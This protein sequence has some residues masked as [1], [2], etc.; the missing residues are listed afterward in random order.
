MRNSSV[1]VLCVL[2]CLALSASAFGQA[3]TTD[4]VGRLTDPDTGLPAAG[5][6][7]S[8]V[9]PGEYFTTTRIDGRFR[10]TNIPAGRYRFAFAYIPG[11]KDPEATLLLAKN[12]AVGAGPALPVEWQQKLLAE[13]DEDEEKGP[14]VR[15]LN[16]RDGRPRSHAQPIIMAE[17]LGV[18]WP[19]SYF[20]VQMSF[21]RGRCRRA[22]LRVIDGSTGDEVPF[23]LSNVKAGARNSVSSCTVTFPASLDPFQKKVYA[24]C[25]GPEG[26]FNEPVYPSSLKVETRE[27]TGEQILSNALVALMLPPAR[28]DKPLP[29]S[30]CPAPI[31]R[32]RGPDGVWFGDGR[33]VS[34]RTVK[35]FKCEEVEKGPLFKEFKITYEFAAKNDAADEK[36]ETADEKTGPADEKKAEP[37]AKYVVTLRLYADRDYVLIREEMSGK[38]DLVFRLSVQANLKPDTALFVKD[39]AAAIEKIRLPAKGD[40]TTLAVFRAWNP[41]GVRNSHNWY[42]L[43]SSG[44]RKDAVGLVQVNGS[45][46]YFEGRDGWGD[47]SWLMKS[48]DDD[49]VRLTATGE[50]GLYL[51]F[52]HR[53]GTREFALAVFDKT[54]NWDAAS[55]AAKRPP[56][57]KT[58]YL[59]RLHVHLSQL[60]IY[61]LLAIRADRAGITPRPRLLFNRKMYAS[62]KESFDENPDKFPTVLHDVFSNS[63]IH[64]SIIRTD[65]LSG[66]LALRH[67]F[68]GQP[69][70]REISGFCSR[71]TSP[72]VIEPI[73]KLTTLLYDAH[74]RSGLFSQ[75]EKQV[76]Q[77]TFALAAA[78]LEHPNYMPLFSHD[79]EAVARRDCALTMLSLLIDRYPRSSTRILQARDRMLREL[80]KAAMT[81]GLPMETGP[82][83][84]AIDV[85]AE[86]ALP[87]DTATGLTRVGGSPFGWPRFV[88]FL[89]RLVT[90][91]APPDRRYG[92]ARLLPTLG[93]SRADD[94]AAQ[95]V[96][97]LAAARFAKVDPRLAGRFAWAWEQA[98]RPQFGQMARHN[99]LLGVLSLVPSDVETKGPEEAE[100]TMLRGFGALLR[101]RFRKPDEA[102]LL[103]KCTPY[104]FSRHHDQGSLIF[105]GLGAPLLI[106]RGSP[107]DRQG[108]WAHNTVRIDSRTH[109]APGRLRQFISQ[110]DDDYVIGEIKV[111]ALSNLK[112][113]TKAELDAA[114]AAASKTKPFVP[115]KGHRADGSQTADMLPTPDKLEQPVLITRHLLFNKHRQYLIV[116]DRIKGY[117]P[118]DVFFNV[119]ADRARTEGNTV[120]F[121]GP[122]GVDLDIHAFAGGPLRATVHKDGPQYFYLRLSQPPPPKPEPK[123]E[124]TE[125]KKPEPDKADAGQEKPD[126]ATETA[127]DEEKAEE[128]GPP[129]I[130]YIT[131]L[132][133]VMRG[134]PGEAKTDY[135]TPPKVEKLKDVTGVRI[136]YGKT[137]RYVFLSDKEVEYQDGTIYFKGKRGVLTIRPTHFDVVLFDTGDIRYKGKGVKTDHGSVRFT[138]AAGGFVKGETSGARNKELVF[139]G[140]GQSPSSLVFRTDGKEFLPGGSSSEAHYGVRHGQHTI[141]IYPR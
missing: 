135:F 97:G 86:M 94:R 92:G 25:G 100:S 51:D 65:I 106:D 24:V 81:G 119:L 53:E 124:K 85:W 31:M 46:W 89:D 12:V 96:M 108:T 68:V 44:A 122:F 82:V 3:P 107:P 104:P 130:D 105:Y 32:L 23:Q 117:L 2:G 45:G 111:D 103:F 67:A 19:K 121:T 8:L 110:D 114:A 1:R 29:A 15:D 17:P 90:L 60:D 88:G 55:L 116:L 129:A 36:A 48:L 83:M 9:D 141:N 137:T 132:C 64:T 75:R 71:M 61:R 7:L 50:P 120:R 125:D 59:N 11:T 28:S 20:S 123:K 91:S 26:W 47:G 113:Y 133:P 21:P 93:L 49:E 41:S 87:M 79:P 136:A 115:P 10:F 33:L 66:V 22:S 73:V 38:I 95:G 6:R 76:I 127:A 37:A 102:Y 4:F 42:G 101:A 74:S 118:T 139:Y 63:R 62:L 134:T 57:D 80:T 39:G 128:Q 140:L 58:H 138:M 98:G 40:S 70:E 126:T 69:N 18:R 77:A 27:G 14:E 109:S 84:R 35:S 34:D 5:V 99:A 72:E 112:E 43:M 16:F 13:R 30:K 54:K 78:Q 52:P 56:R 131:V